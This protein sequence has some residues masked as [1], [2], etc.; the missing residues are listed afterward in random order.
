MKI[1]H[2]PKGLY[3]IDAGHLESVYG[4]AERAAIAGLVTILGPAQTAESIRQRPDLLAQCEVIFTGWG[5]P[6]LDRDFLAAAPQLKLVLYAAGSTRWIISEEMWNREVQ[7]SSSY[8]ANALP[9]VEYTLA[10]LF[11][12]LKHGWRYALKYKQ[13]RGF[14][15]KWPVPGAYG[16]TVGLVSMGIVA[17]MLCEKL[18]SF[19]LHVAVFDPF[20][21][22]GEA[23]ELNVRRVG[24]EELFEISDVVSIH[25]PELPETQGLVTG[26]LIASMKQ[27]ATLINTA[28][29]SVIRENELIEVVSVRP[30]LQIVLDVT[31]PEPPVENSP[32]YHL[33]NVILTPHIAGSMDLECRRMGQA[34]IEELRRYL[35]GEPLQWAITPELARISSHRPAFMNG[36]PAAQKKEEVFT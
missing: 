12:S 23:R 18:R 26:E 15:E 2:R 34:M 5:A 14:P 21:S 31:D 7:L 13:D 27:G 3:I 9:V 19:D 32:L 6:K 1:K 11:F 28:R 24:L 10:T 8:V 30:D 17:R 22:A 16:T 33:P 29:G 4:P 25:A 36:D 35:K 20:L